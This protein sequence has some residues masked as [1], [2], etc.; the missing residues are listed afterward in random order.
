[1]CE[2]GSR[3]VATGSVLPVKVLGILAMLDGGETDWKVIV[4]NSEEAA[5]KKITNLAELTAVQPGLVEAVRRFFTVYKVP[6]GKA[7]NV[8]AYDGEVKDAVLAVE[9]IR[10][11]HQAWREMIGNCSISGE[12]VG[13]FNTGNSLQATTCSVSI[14][15]AKEEV[16]SMPVFDPQEAELPQGVDEWSFLPSSSASLATL[17]LLPALALGILRICTSCY[18]D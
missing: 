16:D 2:V 9:V 14:T 17:S 4:M 7:E 10:Y 15:K 11:T 1:V 5:R 13:S 8:F 12:K 3:P 18:S 6:A